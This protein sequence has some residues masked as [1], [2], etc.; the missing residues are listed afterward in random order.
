MKIKAAEAWADFLPVHLGQI[1]LKRHELSIADQRL[2][3]LFGRTKTRRD[4]SPKP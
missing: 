4:R 2:S 3:V 1:E